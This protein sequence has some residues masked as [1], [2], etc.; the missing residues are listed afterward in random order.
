MRNLQAVLIMMRKAFYYLKDLNRSRIPQEAFRWN[1][2]YTAEINHLPV[3]ATLLTKN[4]EIH[5]DVDDISAKDE[6]FVFS[7]SYN[8]KQCTAK[9]VKKYRDPHFLTCY[10][11]NPNLEDDINQTSNSKGLVNGLTLVLFI[12]NNLISP[13]PPKPYFT[14]NTDDATYEA[15]GDPFVPPAGVEG[16]HVILNQPGICS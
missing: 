6:P 8:N 9:H 10:T 14:D 4:T 15:A 3:L 11:Y 2:N 5:P 7:C 12:G 1:E 16:V 13:K